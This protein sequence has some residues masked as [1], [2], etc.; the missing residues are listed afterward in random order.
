MKTTL[1]YGN[2]LSKSY[3]YQNNETI[4]ETLSGEDLPSNYNSVRQIP[5]QVKQKDEKNVEI[6]DK[7]IEIK[8]KKMEIKTWMYTHLQ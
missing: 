4:D 6:K 2:D 8:E 1:N 7:K 3:L 5:V